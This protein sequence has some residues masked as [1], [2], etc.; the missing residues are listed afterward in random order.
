M[1]NLNFDC[2]CI[3]RY[4]RLWRWWRWSLDLDGFTIISVRWFQHLHYHFWKFLMWFNIQIPPKLLYWHFRWKEMDFFFFSLGKILNVDVDLFF[5]C[6]ICSF[7]VS[8]FWHGTNAIQVT[9]FCCMN[10]FPGIKRIWA[11]HIQ[12][13]ADTPGLSELQL[14]SSSLSIFWNMGSAS[15]LWNGA[16]EDYFV[17]ILVIWFAGISICGFSEDCRMSSCRTHKRG[18]SNHLPWRE[19]KNWWRHH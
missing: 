5:E 19:Q 14:P 2:F 18:I 16:W 10:A 3:W 15:V 6:C 4:K 1:K 9:L 8:S 11:F 13:L 7:F 12:L 17:F